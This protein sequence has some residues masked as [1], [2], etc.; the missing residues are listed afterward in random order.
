MTVIKLDASGDLAGVIK[1][2]ESFSALDATLLLRDGNGRTL[3]S[4]VIDEWSD[5]S[6][7]LRVRTEPVASRI[8][9]AVAAY[10]LGLETELRQKGLL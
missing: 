5:D 3:W 2:L 8:D 9:Q 4:G 1:S 6:H 7:E 10:R